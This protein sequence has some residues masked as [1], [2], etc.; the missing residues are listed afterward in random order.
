M[1]IVLQSC[2][3]V[4]I[5]HIQLCKTMGTTFFP[6]ALSLQTNSET[7]IQRIFLLATIRSATK[8]KLCK[9]TGATKK[10]A[11]LIWRPLH[12][13]DYAFWAQG[14]CSSDK[15]AGCFCSSD[16]DAACF[17]SSEK[18]AVW[19]FSN[20][21]D[22]VIINGGVGMKAFSIKM[23]MLFLMHILTLKKMH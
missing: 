22:A 18:Y 8:C 7:C 2:M 17:C 3:W 16:K 19:F 21:K 15:N 11:S 23:I 6:L 14:F 20:D 9:T 1:P 10:F 5:T 4:I 12:S 13:N